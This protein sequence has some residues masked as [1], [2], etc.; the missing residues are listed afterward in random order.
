MGYSNK[1]EAWWVSQNSHDQ[2]TW[3]Q[4]MEWRLQGLES[5][6]ATPPASLLTALKEINAQA[7]WPASTLAQALL[8]H[9]LGETATPPAESQAGS[10]ITAKVITAS[11]SAVQE[12]ASIPPPTSPSRPSDQTDMPNG[13]AEPNSAY[14]HKHLYN[15]AHPK[16][17]N[18]IS[19]PM[20]AQLECRGCGVLTLFELTPVPAARETSSTSQK[21]AMPSSA[22]SLQAAESGSTYRRISDD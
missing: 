3:M 6:A 5:Q 15:L 22:E 4:F 18:L 19:R 7:S 1:L 11:P 17:W 14:V 8:A 2:L 21:P 20:T 9:I 10:P 12:R 16:G 13:P